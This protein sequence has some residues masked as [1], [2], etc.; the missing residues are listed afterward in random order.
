MKEFYDQMDNTTKSIADML[1][2]ILVEVELGMNLDKHLDEINKAI[3]AIENTIDSAKA[4]GT[5]Y[6]GLETLRNEFWRLKY[7]ILEQI[8]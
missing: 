3:P 6:S 7:E 4:N 5:P 2:N 1:V 8:D